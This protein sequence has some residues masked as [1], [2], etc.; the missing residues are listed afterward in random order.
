MNFKFRI[1]LARITAK[2]QQK[3]Q[4]KHLRITLRITRYFRTEPPIMTFK[5]RNKRT[6]YFLDVVV[7][8]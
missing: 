5:K 7:F 2:S 3:N 6:G 1:F 4:K 8:Y